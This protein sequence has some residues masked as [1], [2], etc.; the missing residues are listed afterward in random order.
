MTDRC[1]PICKQPLKF[2]GLQR[3]DSTGVVVDL[4]DCVNASCAEFEQT[5]S[6]NERPMP[7]EMAAARK[8]ALLGT[9]Q[10]TR[11]LLGMK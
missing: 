3:C 1:C 9:I 6:Y 8:E 4:M 5:H 10:L 2:K 11:A 7:A